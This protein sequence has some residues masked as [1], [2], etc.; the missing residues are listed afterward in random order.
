MA[1]RTRTRTLGRI[2]K[3]VALRARAFGM[4]VIASDPIPDMAFA[5]S[6]SITLMPFEQLLAEADYVTLHPPATAQTKYLINR[7]TL[8]LMKPTAFLLNLASRLQQ[9]GYSSREFRLR[10]T[11]EEIGCYLGMTLETVSRSLSSFA[12]KGYVSVLRRR[13]EI[14]DPQGLRDMFGLSA[15]G[16]L[17]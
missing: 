5:Q 14:L 16:E 13:I 10:M 3:A 4:K 15:A 17:R 7:E 1:P 11:R 12:K 6:Q 9:R 2:G 8:G